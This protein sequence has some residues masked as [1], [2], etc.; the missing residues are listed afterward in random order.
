MAE[1]VKNPIM[2]NYWIFQA[3]VDRWPLE[4]KLIPEQIERWEANQRYGDMAAQD[5]VYFWQTGTGERRM[6]GWG[7]II[8]KPE[9]YEK[10]SIAVKSKLKKKVEAVEATIQ[11]YIEVQYNVKFDKPI[12]LSEFAAEEE[13]IQIAIFGQKGWRGTNLIILPE[14]ARSINKVIMKAGYD[15]PPDPPIDLEPNGIAKLLH[16]RKLSEGVYNAE[17]LSFGCAIRSG[18]SIVRVEHLLLGLFDQKSTEIESVFSEARVQR[19]ALVSKLESSLGYPLSEKYEPLTPEEIEKEGITLGFDPNFKKAQLSSMLTAENENAEAEQP[20]HLLKGVFSLQDIEIVKELKNIAELLERRPI[21]DIFSLRNEAMDDKWTTEDRLD[22]TVYADAVAQPI[23]G[24]KWKPPLTIGIQA[25]WGQGKTSLM[26]MIQQRLDPE[27]V[28]LELQG[29]D[30]PF[31]VKTTYRKFF[32][33]LKNRTK[34]NSLLPRKE[35]RTP[36]VWFKPLVYETSEQIWSGLAHAILHQ[37]ARKFTNDEDRERFWLRLS[38]AR[39]DPGVLKKGFRNLLIKRFFTHP[40]TLTVGCLLAL[41]VGISIVFPEELISVFKASGYPLTEKQLKFNSTVFSLLTGLIG[42]LATCVKML[43]AKLDDKFRNYIPAPDYEG[44]LGF[45][46]TI[47]DDLNLA[48]KMLV[49]KN[50]VVVF[51]DDLDRCTPEVVSE[52]VMAIYRFMLLESNNFF[53]ILGMDM[54][55]VVTALE[56]EHE[57]LA[58]AFRKTGQDRKSF[59]WEF[60]DKF[61]QVPFFIP[62]LG[63]A[64][65]K[66]YLGGFLKGKDTQVPEQE[67]EIIHQLAS[68]VESS[69][70]SESLSD[71]ASNLNEA[72]VKGD[73]TTANLQ[74]LKKRLSKKAA[75]VL[76]G[77]ESKE[78]DELVNVAIEDLN[79]NPRVIKRFINLAGLL[80]QIHVVQGNI[81][82]MEDSR[83]SVVRAAHLIMNWPRAVGWLQANNQ[84]YSHKGIRTSSG[85]ALVQSVDHYKDFT[86]WRE[87]LESDWGEDVLNILGRQ[88]LHDFLGRITQNPPGL[89]ELFEAGLL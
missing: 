32:E 27:A 63:K 30:K 43:A 58:T 2:Q 87:G 85:K 59:G 8:G 76:L 9:N 31:E 21:H 65:T 13:L 1:P 45:L 55:M 7:K 34:S 46:H 18:D 4:E 79:Y 67:A 74:D 60:M 57:K 80:W 83:L 48:L 6:Y 3:N 42:L 12:P 11:N 25:Q 64:L 72:A 89:T 66:N 52:A 39:E 70:N 19:D 41:M 10:E 17:S 16:S 5:V 54:Q 26:K 44:K 20:I 53:F 40:A 68:E 51:I 78:I 36:T 35:G 69:K 15:L 33:L 84:V 29:E 56:V 22:Y 88:S 23:L 37:L 77:P 86:K 73:I 62:H 61:I 75:K 24:E 14:Q 82:K 28:D 38:L 81:Q 49:G 50:P 71:V 47:N